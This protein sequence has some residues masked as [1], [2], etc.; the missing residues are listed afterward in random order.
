MK[1][2]VTGTQGQLARSLLEVAKLPDTSV[3]ALGR[4]ELDLLNPTTIL[5]RAI[6]GAAPDVV[7]NAAAYTATDK[8]EAE[9]ELAYAINAEG[10]GRVAEVCER[11]NTPL[12]H[13]STDYV[14][15]GGVTGP[16][17]EADRAA[18]LGVYGHSKLEGERRVADRCQRHII[19]RIA[20]V[21]SPFG[22]NF[23]K[24]MLQI[25]KG[26]SEIGVVDDQ[27]GN[28]T[29]ALHL[30]AGILAI[31]RQIL[32]SPDKEPP[33]GIYHAAGSGETTWFRFAQEV[34][35]QSERL[36]GPMARLRPISTTEYSVAAKRPADS[37]LDC[38]KCA[39]VFGVRLP[40]WTIGVAE[41][42]WRLVGDKARPATNTVGTP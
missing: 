42:V 22:D 18:P 19:L 35:S 26:R 15:G 41:C 3:V 34:F 30:A 40:D 33:W 8:A 9:P 23:V 37:R 27:I 12:I 11:R 17:R 25:A 2:L 24:S 14:F 28:P 29:Y 6:D 31:A 7:I 10:A 32:T 1:L 21:H 4:P 16:Y 38:S 5:F 20:W 39:R 13:I 36:R